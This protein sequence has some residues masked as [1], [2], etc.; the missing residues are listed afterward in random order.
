MAIKRFF[1]IWATLSPD[2]KNLW[3]STAQPIRQ[4]ATFETIFGS[5]HATVTTFSPAYVD[6]ETGH[7]YVVE[8]RWPRWHPFSMHMTS[9]LL[10]PTLI[11]REKSRPGQLMLKTGIFLQENWQRTQTS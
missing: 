11:S 10:I 9:W 3:T 4:L 5:L 2:S 6:I 8:A 7:R 1:T